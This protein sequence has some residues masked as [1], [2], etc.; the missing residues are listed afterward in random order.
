[1][2]KR[3]SLA[4]YSHRF[5]AP[6]AAA[7]RHHIPCFVFPYSPPLLSFLNFHYGSL[8][9]LLN[10]LPRV[11]CLCF[12]F[13]LEYPMRC[14]AGRLCLNIY[15]KLLKFFQCSTS[16]AHTKHTVGYTPDTMRAYQTDNNRITMLDNI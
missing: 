2:C 15:V 5:T 11:P 8:H 4:R 12:K 3:D 13:Y 7:R 6:F 14:H 9:A 10:I 1:M 16:F